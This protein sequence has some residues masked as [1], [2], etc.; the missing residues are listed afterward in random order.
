LNLKQIVIK[1]NWAEAYDEWYNYYCKEKKYGDYHVFESVLLQLQKMNIVESKLEYLLVSEFKEEFDGF[2][3]EYIAVSGIEGNVNYGISYSKLNEL[4]VLEI[5]QEDVNLSNEQLLAH[6]IWELSWNGFDEE[7]IQKSQD[8]LVERL[9]EV[10]SGEAKLVSW[11]EMKSE[12]GFD[13]D[14][15]EN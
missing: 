7:V 11:E 10:E 12:L 2:K 8:E 4:A 5:K 15:E 13:F 1:S 6:I 3:N 9:K 14:N